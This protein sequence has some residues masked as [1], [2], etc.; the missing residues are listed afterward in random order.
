MTVTASVP[1]SYMGT[2]YKVMPPVM[3]QIEPLQPD[4]VSKNEFYAMEI[5]GLWKMFKGEAMGGPYVSHTRLHPET[6]RI[7]TAEVYVLAPGQKKRNI[8]RKAEA[9]LYSWSW[10]K[11]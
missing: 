7:I 5:R 9:Q 1:G 11:K 6:Q 4:S 2:E 10:V 8:L 3:R